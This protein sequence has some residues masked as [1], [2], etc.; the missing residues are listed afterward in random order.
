MTTKA[1]TASKSAAAQVEEAMAVGKETVEQAVKASAESYGQ[2]VAMTKEQVEKAST[3][4]FKSYDDLATLNKENI[5]AVLK[6]GNILA[7]GAESVGKAYFDLFQ[8][9]AE[10]GVEATKALLT[11]RTVKDVVDV[12]TDFA[13]TSF[14][15]FVAETTRISELTVK[16]TNEAFQPIQAQFANTLAKTLKAPTA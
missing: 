10:A 7:K 12:Q 11:A 15:T 1:K 5:E 4:F 9:A 16:V 13:R 8:T 6:A 3:A 2:A 14:D